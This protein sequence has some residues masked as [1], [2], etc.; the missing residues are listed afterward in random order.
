M[1]FKQDKPAAPATLDDVLKAIKALDAKVSKLVAASGNGSKS[2]GNASSEGEIANDY[3]LDSEHGNPTIKKDPPRW[4]GDSFAGCTYSECTPEY[5]D[6]LAGFHDWRVWKANQE[7]NEKGAHWA[8]KDAARARGWAR[9]LRNGW[10]TGA[11][12]QRQQQPEGTQWNGSGSY[13]P[14][15]NEPPDDPGYPT[16]DEIDDGSIPF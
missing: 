12:P 6:A 11:A 9:R 3:D 7:G 8:G 10:E 16:G 5:L 15:G 13:V 1:A 14:S 4:E 2:R